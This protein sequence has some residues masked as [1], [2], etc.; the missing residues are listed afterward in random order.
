[1]VDGAGGDKRRGQPQKPEESPAEERGERRPVDLH[2]P[3]SRFDFEP[4][5]GGD[6]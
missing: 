4:T 5:T 2:D 1:M 6:F 3:F